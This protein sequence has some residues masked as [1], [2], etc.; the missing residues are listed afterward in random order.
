MQAFILSDN[1]VRAKQLESAIEEFVD[2]SVQSQVFDLKNPDSAVNLMHMLEQSRLV[3]ADLWDGMSWLRAWQ[4]GMCFDQGLP[5]VLYWQTP[6][7]FDPLMQAVTAVRSIP[8]LRRV[9][10]LISRSI[11][12]DQET[13]ALTATELHMEFMKAIQ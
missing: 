3:V 7:K 9:S 8:Q 11:K 2:D 13:Y 4:L 10:Y 5:V 6:I 12:E 1:S